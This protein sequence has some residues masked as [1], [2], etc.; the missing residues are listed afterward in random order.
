MIRTRAGVLD[1][2]KSAGYSS[3]R[4]RQ[5]KLLGQRMIQ[6]IRER[7]PV[8]GEALDLLCRLLA[9]QPG[10]VLEYVPDDKPNKKEHED[11]EPPLGDYAQHS[12]DGNRSD[13][14]SVLALRGGIA[15]VRAV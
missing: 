3:Y 15:A 7:K 4:L 9:C 11:R 13:N 1:R 8:S 6:Q 12:P 10:D 5:E 2:L 14:R